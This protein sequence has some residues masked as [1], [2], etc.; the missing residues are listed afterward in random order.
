LGKRA[1]AT[2][3]AIEPAM[4]AIMRDI[5]L[6]RLTMG[7]VGQKMTNKGIPAPHTLKILSCARAQNL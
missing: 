4:L 2:L 5:P 6:T 7:Y 1:G 3:Q